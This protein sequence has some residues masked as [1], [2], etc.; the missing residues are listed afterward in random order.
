MLKC[1]FS[2]LLVLSA[3]F[4]TSA[5]A[6]VIDLRIESKDIR[7]SK[8]V[9]VAGD[10]IRIYARIYNVGS[11][12]V[13]GYL[14]FYQ[15]AIALH[16]PQV[17]SLVTNS[18]PEEVFV[19]FVVPTSAFNIRAI[20]SGTVPT[21]T[22]TSNNMAMTTMITPVLDDDHDGIANNVDNCPVIANSNQLDTDH[23]GIGDACDDDADNDGLTN[24]VESEL[25]T[26]ILLKDTDGD[27]VNDPNDAYPLDPNRSVIE[28]K[29]IPKIPVPIVPPVKSTNT[30]VSPKIT[31]EK[32]SVTEKTVT[33]GTSAPSLRELTAVT[34]S[35]EPSLLSMSNDAISTTGIS[36]NAIFK[37]EQ[38][39]WN[40]EIFSVLSPSNQNVNYEWNFG[41]GVRS[42]KPTVTHVYEK[43]GTYVVTLKTTDETG[44]TS[45]ESTTI[46]IP[47]FR[48]SNPII[49]Y[50][51]GGLSFLLLVACASLLLLKPSKNQLK[52][53]KSIEEDEI[54]E[55]P[56]KRIHVK[57]E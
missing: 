47:F 54:D 14:T 3:L 16:E 30:Q 17:I 26:N 46:N 2:L 57:E 49:Q 56:I 27:A 21:E 31:S 40:T 43:P 6:A 48:L 42:S 32:S 25:G 51:I 34:P 37:Y 50:A 28:K 22:N 29:V 9:L 10:S 18:D 24:A 19:D 44:T 53:V 41:D 20:I 4:P 39:R 45:Q 15:G 13:V 52:I 12:D 35:P 23:D 1:F 55:E 38:I 7:F 36:P 5:F 33:Q 8:P 11:E